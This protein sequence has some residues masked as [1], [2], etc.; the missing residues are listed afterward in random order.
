MPTRI[1]LRKT[2]GFSWTICLGHHAAEGVAEDVARLDLE[3]FE[4]CEGV[5][6]HS[7]HGFRYRATGAPDARTIEENQFALDRKLIRYG[8][9]PIIQRSREVLKQQQWEPVGFSETAIRIPLIRDVDELRRRCDVAR[10]LRC[11]HDV[12]SPRN[13]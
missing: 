2:D 11:G 10:G 3:R 13:R 9:V 1:I 8:R 6:C 5:L 4:K 7:S 12:E